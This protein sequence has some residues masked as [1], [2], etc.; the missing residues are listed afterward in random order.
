MSL[1]FKIPEYVL[2]REG[3]DK[4]KTTGGAF[5]CRLEGCRGRRIAIRWAEG[6]MTY[7]CSKGLKVRKDL[8]STWQI[9]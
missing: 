4:G 7:P 2:D 6:R 9:L 8:E 3:T 1:F 5:P